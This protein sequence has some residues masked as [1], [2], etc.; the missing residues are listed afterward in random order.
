MRP[1][2]TPPPF[3]PRPQP[4]SR[5]PHAVIALAPVAEWADWPIWR[6][7]ACHAP[8]TDCPH[9]YQSPM[10]AGWECLACRRTLMGPPP[11]QSAVPG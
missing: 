2:P 11:A 4:R 9:D 3:T 7:V 6:C 10:P 1:R 5:C 8:I